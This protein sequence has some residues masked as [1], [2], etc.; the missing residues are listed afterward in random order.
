[1]AGKGRGKSTLSLLTVT[2]FAIVLKTEITSPHL[3]PRLNVGSA[4]GRLSVGLYQRKQKERDDKN[5]FH[6]VSFVFW[7]SH[8]GRRQP[9]KIDVDVP[10]S[11]A[12]SSNPAVS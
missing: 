2:K 8:L 9:P 3:F 6:G 7:N 4:R 10:V 1:M 12:P 11:N 5:T